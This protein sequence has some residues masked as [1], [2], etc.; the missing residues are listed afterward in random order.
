VEGIRHC[1]REEAVWSRSC[2][3]R[4]SEASRRGP[5]E[6]EEVGDAKPE[7]GRD[8]GEVHTETVPRRGEF[9]AEKET[10]FSRLSALAVAREPRL[11]VTW[12]LAPSNVF[13]LSSR[14]PE[15]WVAVKTDRV[16]PA[17]TSGAAPLRIRRENRDLLAGAKR[18]FMGVGAGRFSGR[19]K[20]LGRNTGE[21]NRGLAQA[22]DESV[23]SPLPG[24]IRR[25][26]GLLESSASVP[27]DGV[28]VASAGARRVER[29]SAETGRRT[30]GR[31]LA[32]AA[33]AGAVLARGRFGRASSCSRSG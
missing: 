29:T 28:A 32:A 31:S 19:S 15:W 8:A 4:H 12:V 14:G 6:R 25:G 23:A 16:G 26:D 27:P 13:R 33:C 22:E 20:A 17:A 5:G 10:F 24:V 18:A 9:V 3:C 11:G 30:G 21:G 7:E 2:S 1:G